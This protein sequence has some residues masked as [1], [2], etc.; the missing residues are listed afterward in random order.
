MWNEPK[1]H[2]SNRVER[3]KNK[4]PKWSIESIQI[5]D[6]AAKNTDKIHLKLLVSHITRIFCIMY[7]YYAEW[8]R[9]YRILKFSNRTIF[10]L[11][12]ITCAEPYNRMQQARFIDC[13]FLP[14]RT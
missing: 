13:I 3:N 11:L 12:H 4:N 5:L 9:P 7:K 1:Q 10:N 6:V 14:S 8:G 2:G